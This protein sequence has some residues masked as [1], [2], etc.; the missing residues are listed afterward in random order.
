MSGEAMPSAAMN[1]GTDAMGS[2]YR[3]VPGATRV[4][5]EN[6]AFGDMTVVTLASATAAA[7]AYAYAELGRAYEPVMGYSDWHTDVVRIER[8]GT[9]GTFTFHIYAPN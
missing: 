3:S 6:T 1:K 4:K 8:F 9:G 2:V 5:F 7:G